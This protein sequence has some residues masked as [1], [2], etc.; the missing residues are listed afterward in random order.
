MQRLKQCR[1]GGIAPTLLCDV[2]CWKITETD[3]NARIILVAMKFSDKDCYFEYTHSALAK[4]FAS[5]AYIQENKTI[6]M[7]INLNLHLHRHC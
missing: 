5:L 3:S 6:S 1:T 4:V 2:A 7:R